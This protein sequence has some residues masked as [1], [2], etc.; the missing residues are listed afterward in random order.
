MGTRISLCELLNELITYLFA[1][2]K[3]AEQILD[4][5]RSLGGRE[6][7]N[8]AEDYVGLVVYKDDEIAETDVVYTF[9]QHLISI[10]KDHLT[11][12]IQLITRYK[13]MNLFHSNELLFLNSYLLRFYLLDSTFLLIK[14]NIST[15]WCCMIKYYNR[16]LKGRTISCS[17]VPFCL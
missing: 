1:L 10:K 17:I 13:T 16:K 9:L 11:K 12:G 4:E 2:S 15:L 3:I 8:L 5:E 6:L 14:I 7:T